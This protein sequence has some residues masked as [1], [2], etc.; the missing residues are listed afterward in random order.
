VSPLPPPLN[1][2]QNK[3]RLLLLGAGESG[4]STIF[5]QMRILYGAG[6][7]DQER[8][9]K[10][11]SIHHNTISFIKIL[12][13]QASELGHDMTSSKEEFETVLACSESDPITEDMGQKIKKLWA[14]PESRRPGPPRATTKS[15]NRMQNI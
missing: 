14:D 2:Q 7:S 13:S 3:I 11:S 5:K 6:F 12:C 15:L 10:V 8:H 4:K 9:Q 1:Q